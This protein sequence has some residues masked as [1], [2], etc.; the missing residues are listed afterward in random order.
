ML[1]I[2]KLEKKLEEEL[3]DLNTKL[4]EVDTEIAAT[5]AK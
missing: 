5:E 4:D 3:E 1:V 2:G